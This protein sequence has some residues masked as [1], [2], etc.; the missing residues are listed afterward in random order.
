MG[1]LFKPKKFEWQTY[2]KKCAEEKTK[3]KCINLKNKKEE[4]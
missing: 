2:C 1:K 4:L 3:C